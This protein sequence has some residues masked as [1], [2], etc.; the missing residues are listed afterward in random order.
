MQICEK[1]RDFVG[2]EKVLL[3]EPVTVID[4]SDDYVVNVSTATGKTFR[5]KYVINASPLHCSGKM[6]IRAEVKNAS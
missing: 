2:Q 5:C 1:L 6:M 4:Q 3:G